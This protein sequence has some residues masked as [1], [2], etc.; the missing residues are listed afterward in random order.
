MLFHITRAKGLE[1]ATNVAITPGGTQAY[2]TVSGPGGGYLYTFDA[3]AEAI[4][5]DRE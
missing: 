3:S 5:P 1:S 2:M 4:R